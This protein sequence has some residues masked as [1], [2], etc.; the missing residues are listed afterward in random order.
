M[1]TEQM[2]L[3]KVIQFPKKVIEEKEK[4]KRF[5]ILGGK[6]MKG[7]ILHKMFNQTYAVMF[8][9]LEDAKKY[10]EIHGDTLNIIKID[11]I[12]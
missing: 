7:R 6:I 5:E 1:K 9:S 4:W 3:M 8:D 10:A 11:K 12:Y 2:K